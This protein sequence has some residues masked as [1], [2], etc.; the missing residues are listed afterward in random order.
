[1]LCIQ[2]SKCFFFLCYFILGTHIAIE[3]D[4]SNEIE[5][6]GRSY[7]ANANKSN[8]NQM[9]KIGASRLKTFSIDFNPIWK[10]NK[11]IF[12]ISN[13]FDTFDDDTWNYELW[14]YILSSCIHSFYFPPLQILLICIWNTQWVLPILST[15]LIKC[16]TIC[17][18]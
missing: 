9:Y 7:T 18:N 4:G 16:L 12:S 1:M 15:V 6:F 14:W 5:L 13:M 2:K 10:K 8:W 11:Y 17:K 3:S